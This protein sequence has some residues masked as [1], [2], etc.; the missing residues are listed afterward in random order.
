MV[1]NPAAVPIVVCAEANKRLTSSLLV[2]AACID[3][4]IF[5]WQAHSGH[6][7]II[8]LRIVRVRS[9]NH[10]VFAI[11]LVGHPALRSRQ[12]SDG[13]TM[14]QKKEP[15]QCVQHLNSGKRG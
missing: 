9:Q 14:W 12:D 11:V 5:A 4:C 10:L 1:L 6:H 7:Q 3:L 13:G 2:V 8:R 15:D